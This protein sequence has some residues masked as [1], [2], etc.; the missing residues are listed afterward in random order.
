MAINTCR[1][2]STVS[3]VISSGNLTNKPSVITNHQTQPKNIIFAQI[4]VEEWRSSHR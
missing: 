3:V 1:W 2:W 4:E